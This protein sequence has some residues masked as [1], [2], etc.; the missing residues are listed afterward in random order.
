MVIKQWMHE[1]HNC[2][3]HDL[4]EPLKNEDF[5][6]R[7]GI[8]YRFHQSGKCT[9]INKKFAAVRRSPVPLFLTSLVPLCFFCVACVFC[10]HRHFTCKFPYK[11]ALVREHVDCA[12]SHKVCVGV[13]VHRCSA[14]C[15]L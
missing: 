3:R 6:Q 11:E 13:L 4:I 10:C 5:T 2:R 8:F 14:A 15:F 1:Y 7:H 9:E 12:A